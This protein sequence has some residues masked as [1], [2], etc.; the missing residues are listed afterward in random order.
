M[1]IHLNKFFLRS[2]R[3][4][5]SFYLGVFEDLLEKKNFKG[6]DKNNNSNMVGSKVNTKKQNLLG[7]SAW[8]L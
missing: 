1:K 2:Y 7:I 5:Q 6:C 3:T 4:Q 8:S